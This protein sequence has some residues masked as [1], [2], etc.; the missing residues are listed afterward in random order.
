[1][2]DAAFAAGIGSWSGAVAGY[3]GGPKAFHVWSHDDWKRFERNRKLPIWVAGE[4]GEDEGWECLKALRKLGVPKN[5]PVVV[6]METR[7]DIS[8]LDNWGE[9]LRWG[10]YRPW[11]YGSAS[12]VFGNPPLNGY[13]VADFKGERPFLYD[14]DFVRATQWAQGENFDSS[15]IKRI[16]YGRLWR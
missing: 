12:T 2:R 6:D 10:G 15:A 16:S 1:M 9:I 5:V 7:V 13:W 8:Y 14:H 4:S 3:L 11:V